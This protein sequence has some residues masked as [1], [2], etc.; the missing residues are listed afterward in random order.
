MTDQYIRKVDLVVSSGS[1]GL[2]LSQFKIVFQTHQ[3]DVDQPP[4]AEITIYNLAAETSKQIQNEFQYVAL[5]AGYVDGNVGVIFQGSIKQF[6][7]GRENNI[8]SFLTIFAADG[9]TAYNFGL[10]SKALAAG[11]SLRDQVNVIL[12]TAAEKGVTAGSI[13]ETI[14][15]GGTLPRG[16]VL[17]G[18]GLAQLTNIA[19]SGNCSWFIQ[20]GQ[21]NIVSETGYLSDEAVVLNART[22]MIGVPEATNNGIEVRSL[23]NPMIKVGTRVKID[24]ASINQTTVISQGFPRYTDLSFPASVNADGIYRVLVVEHSGDTR[25]NEYYTRMTCLSVDPS[26]APGASVQPYG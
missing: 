6:R 25:G 11:A 14:G 15:T 9:D 5:Q 7:S 23:L 20:N 3:M 17:F 24:N 19:N 1:K 13:P 26:A 4:T 8:N 18:L 16:K 2:D 12:G 22:G 10:T 21:L